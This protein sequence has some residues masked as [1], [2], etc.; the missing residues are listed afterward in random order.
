MGILSQ[1]IFDYGVIKKQ[2]SAIES[3]E[4]KVDGKKVLGKERDEILEDALT[5][6]KAELERLRILLLT[7]AP[8]FYISSVTGK[9]YEA[10]SEELKHL[11]K[12]P[13]PARKYSVF[14]AK[15]S[16]KKTLAPKSRFELYDSPSKNVFNFYIE[17][18]S[19]HSYPSGGFAAKVKKAYPTADETTPRYA[20]KVFKKNAFGTDTFHELR[21]AMRS[22]YCNRLL[23]RTGYAFRQNNKQYIVTDWLAG[24]PLN[25]VD[26]KR[27]ADIPIQKRLNLARMLIKE[28]AILHKHGIIHCDIKPE[29]VML[30]DDALHLFDLDSVRL[31][32]ENITTFTYSSMYTPNYL[33]AQC[34]YDLKNNPSSLSKMLNK[35]SDIFATGLTLLFLFSDVLL[36]IREKQ[37][38]SIP[39]TVPPEFFAYDGFSVTDG[40]KLK[41]NAHLANFLFKILGDSKNRP[42]IEDVQ[43]E[44]TNLL[45]KYST[46]K[47]EIKEVKAEIKETAHPTKLSS[48]TVHS[49]GR[50]AFIEIESELMTFNSSWDRFVKAFNSR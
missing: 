7:G 46:D 48:S 22:A 38:I 18:K 8:K 15:A 2:I 49:T 3:A 9:G 5:A 17:H 45:K 13:F 21:I 27:I 14:S 39:N 6:K 12:A 20:V 40:G 41:E 16:R 31:E 34:N 30:S 24:I 19:D 1:I 42:N 28:I 29:N 36:P 10:S 35:K 11:E 37:K 23:G 47:S 32:K 4:L 25:Q 33:D 50:E 44:L 26:K 43:T